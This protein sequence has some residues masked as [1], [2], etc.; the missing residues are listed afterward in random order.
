MADPLAAG[1]S[2]KDFALP[3]LD[4]AVFDSAAARREGLLLYVFWKRTCGTCQFTFPYLQR[5]QVLYAGPGFR[6][7]GIAQE[8]A[9]DTLDFTRLYGVT[10]PQLIDEDYAVSEEYDL[11]GVPA[12]YLAD[13][14]EK[15]LGFVGGFSTDELNRFA[16]I[17]AT[18]TGKPYTPI[19][20]PEDEAPRFKPG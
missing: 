15:I 4:G 20:R 6:L 1:D 13:G 10:F 18:R 7:W 16:E 11:D 9:E 5:F 3:S 19:V 17:I 2:V 12:C 8:N 14:S